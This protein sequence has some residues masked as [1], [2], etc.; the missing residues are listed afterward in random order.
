ME[1]ATKIS[2]KHAMH[3]LD[4][5]KLVGVEYSSVCATCGMVQNISPNGIF[6]LIGA[7]L[8]DLILVKPKHI[9]VRTSLNRRRIILKRGE[10]NTH[11]FACKKLFEIA[12]YLFADNPNWVQVYVEVP[13][14]GGLVQGL[15]TRSVFFG[16]AKTNERPLSVMQ[17]RMNSVNKKFIEQFAKRYTTSRLS[18][19]IAPKSKLEQFVAKWTNNEQ[20]KVKTCKA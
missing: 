12:L 16:F 2:C 5:T 20:F 8:S 18:R 7:P 1:K 14:R 13:Y 6:E 3:Y 17:K 11:Y 4:A 19:Y 15:M 10:V 9:S